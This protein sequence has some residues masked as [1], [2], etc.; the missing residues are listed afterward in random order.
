MSVVRPKIIRTKSR[1]HVTSAWSHFIHFLSSLRRVFIHNFERCCHFII[2]FSF[3][4]AP[5]NV[6]DCERLVKWDARKKCST[7]NSIRCCFDSQHIQLSRSEPKFQFTKMNF[8]FRTNEQ[9]LKH[10]NEPDRNKN[11]RWRASISNRWKMKQKSLM[12]R[13]KH[14]LM[15]AMCARSNVTKQFVLVHFGWPIASSAAPHTSISDPE[16]DKHP[17]KS[18][19]IKHR[20]SSFCAQ[21]PARKKQ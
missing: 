21:R 11:S 2:T 10:H 12:L 5:C 7:D 8:A 1:N 16:N 13:R 19:R 4:G 3:F 18:I 9:K 6:E 20:I 17:S 14:K 15:C